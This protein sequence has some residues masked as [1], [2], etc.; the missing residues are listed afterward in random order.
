M[1]GLFIFKKSSFKNLNFFKFSMIY[2]IR[3]LNFN[4]A[5][6]KD[7]QDLLSDSFLKG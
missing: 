7:A 6:S 4:L 1:I 2:H 5:I 3:F